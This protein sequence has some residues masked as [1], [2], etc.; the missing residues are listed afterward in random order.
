MI[1]KRYACTDDLAAIR[2]IWSVAFP[3]DLAAD[4]DRF[5]SAVRLSE[6][7][8]VAEEDGVPISMVFMLPVVYG[9]QRWQYIYAAATLPQHRGR[10]VFA[11]LLNAA[12]SQAKEQGFAGSFLHPAEPSL[13]AYYARFGY[14]VWNGVRTVSGKAA[15][16]ESVTLLSPADYAA[17]RPALLPPD[18][19]MWEPRFTAY[20][21]S[22][23]I[24]VGTDRALALCYVQDGTLVI[25]ELFG[26]VEPSALCAALG[27]DRFVWRCPDG[28]EPFMLF[29]PFVSGVENTSPYVGL[30]LD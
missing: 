22:C 1:V 13:I 2:A 10:G 29:L 11:A 28:D 30:A 12:L 27:C 3:E 7:C 15:A 14:R 8:L 25:R 23:G 5:L 20:A 19:V 9:E 4:R 26:D 21:A 16:G 18:A 6:E 24:A 17:R